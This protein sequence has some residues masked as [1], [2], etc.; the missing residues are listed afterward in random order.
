MNVNIHFSEFKGEFLVCRMI[1]FAIITA[2]IRRCLSDGASSASVLPSVWLPV[3]LF[4]IMEFDVSW[5]SDRMSFEVFAVGLMTQ[6]GCCVNFMVSFQV[7]CKPYHVI[8]FS[9]LAVGWRLPIFPCFR[10][11][12]LCVNWQPR[13]MMD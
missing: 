8:G 13:I 6:S 12:H 11:Q 10:N 3:R 4:R 5:G 1:C 7:G 9:T 2:A